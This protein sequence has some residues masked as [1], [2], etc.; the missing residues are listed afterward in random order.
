M[1]EGNSAVEQGF[2]FANGNLVESKAVA[3]LFPDAISRSIRKEQEDR[4]KKEDPNLTARSSRLTRS[5]KPQSEVV[6]EM[7]EYQEAHGRTLARIGAKLL[8]K[9]SEKKQMDR[10][11]CDK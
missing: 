8:T 4:G 9:P 1:R 5:P 7:L 6:A 11:L 2:N 3:R 10:D